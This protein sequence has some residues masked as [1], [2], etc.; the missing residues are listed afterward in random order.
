VGRLR[1]KVKPLH[2][3]TSSRLIPGVVHLSAQNAQ[4]PGRTPWKPRP[5]SM[6]QA[7]LV[8]A[9]LVK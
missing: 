7:F 8:W 1:Q 9:P 2:E 5:T 6:N 3:A 4:E